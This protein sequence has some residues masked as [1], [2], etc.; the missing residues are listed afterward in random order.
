MPRW[1]S[2]RDGRPLGS[3]PIGRPSFSGLVQPSRLVF[4]DNCR[5]SPAH[6][7][8]IGS[9]R[10]DNRSFLDSE[11]GRPSIKKSSRA[12]WIPQTSRIE[13]LTT[14]TFR[15]SHSQATTKRTERPRRSS[16]CPHLHRVCTL[17]CLEWRG[18]W[19]LSRPFPAAR[20]QCRNTTGDEQC[21]EADPRFTPVA[22]LP[23]ID[24]NQYAR[25][26]PAF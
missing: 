3:W 7:F 25:R 21:S 10:N 11:P 8:L 6:H 4:T 9:I 14:I 12:G 16:P 2:A 13:P 20:D 17:I 18:R 23:Q 1:S 19:G 5:N 24:G 22:K 15:F 26:A